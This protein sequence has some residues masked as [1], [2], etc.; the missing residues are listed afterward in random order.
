MKD[1]RLC[2][3][4]EGR[5]PGE[6]IRDG[7]YGEPKTELATASMSLKKRMM[8]LNGCGARFLSA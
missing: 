3:F 7:K 5:Y 4:Q 1:A 8:E 2:K 6:E